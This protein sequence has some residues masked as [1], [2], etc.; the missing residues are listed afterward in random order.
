MLQEQ[1]EKK[2]SFNDTQKLPS[3]DELQTTQKRLLQ[4]IS[5]VTARHSARR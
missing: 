5:Y 4:K 2:N 1:Q 3:T